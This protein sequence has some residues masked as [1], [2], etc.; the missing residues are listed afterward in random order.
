MKF[1]KVQMRAHTLTLADRAAQQAA[2]PLSDHQQALAAV[3][4]YAAAAKMTQAQ[5]SA[6]QRSLKAAVHGFAVRGAG[7]Q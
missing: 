6:H 4:A 2:R 1:H 5:A 7:G 3:M